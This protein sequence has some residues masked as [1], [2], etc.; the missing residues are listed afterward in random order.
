M[1]SICMSNFFM[2]ELEIDELV[3]VENPEKQ[4]GNDLY[5]H[6][7]FPTPAVDLFG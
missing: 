7:Q 5:C 4:D 2:S 6:R 3:I 1:M